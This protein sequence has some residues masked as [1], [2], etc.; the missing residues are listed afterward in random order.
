MVRA[1]PVDPPD[2]DTTAENIG[3]ESD[4]DVCIGNKH[5]IL[6]TV[7]NHCTSSRLKTSS[8]CPRSD[9]RINEK[10]VSPSGPLL[11]DV[12]AGSRLPPDDSAAVVVIRHNTRFGA[13]RWST[14]AG[15]LVFYC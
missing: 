13:S 14:L 3:R 4:N 9:V 12:G 7:E 15:S 6:G 11:E 5:S 1:W 2:F 8:F 10:P